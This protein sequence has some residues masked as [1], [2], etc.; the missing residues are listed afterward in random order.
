VLSSPKRF[1]ILVCQASSP[2]GLCRSTDSRASA[3]KK[4]FVVLVFMK[5]GGAAISSVNNVIG[6]T[7]LLPTRDSRD[8]VGFITALLGTATGK[9]ACPSDSASLP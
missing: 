7:T 1:A 2:K 8:S 4:G 5:N 3:R 9:V 6:I